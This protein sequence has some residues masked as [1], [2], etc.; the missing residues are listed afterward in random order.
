MPYGSIVKRA[1]GKIQPAL[2][3]SLPQKPDPTEPAETPEDDPSESLGNALFWGALFWIGVIAVPTWFFANEENRSMVKNIA[4]TLIA[5][6]LMCAWLVADMIKKWFKS[7]HLITGLSLCLI[8]LAVILWLNHF[9]VWAIAL[10]LV[11]CATDCIVLLKMFV[12]A[13]LNHYDEENHPQR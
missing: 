10:I 12:E 11:V 4:L 9:D 6:D 3:M 13:W 2:L 5:L 8:V 1:D 7:K